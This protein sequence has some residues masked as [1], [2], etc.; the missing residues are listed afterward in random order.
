MKQTRIKTPKVQSCLT[1]FEQTPKQPDR[2]IDALP[3]KGDWLPFN[4]E[5]PGLKPGIYWA[6][7]Y[8]KDERLGSPG[9]HPFQILIE[10]M[11]D[12][13]ELK[14]M[15]TASITW[16]VFQDCLPR[17]SHVQQVFAPENPYTGTQVNEEFA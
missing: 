4:Q 10:V 14:L 13:H 15:P 3:L 5:N 2:A 9:L 12:R 17:I 8:R 11:S 1:G 6:I 7:G 16:L